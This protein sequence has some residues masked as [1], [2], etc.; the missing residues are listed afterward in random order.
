M[1][2]VKWTNYNGNIE[3]KKKKILSQSL[4]ICTKPFRHKWVVNSHTLEQIRKVENTA[5]L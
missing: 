5:N 2:L 1:G 3:I 4:K